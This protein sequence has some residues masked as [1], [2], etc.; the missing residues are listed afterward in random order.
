MNLVT[1]NRWLQIRK[2]QNSLHA[3]SSV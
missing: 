1:N 2:W 3:S